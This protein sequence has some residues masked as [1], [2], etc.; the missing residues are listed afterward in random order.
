[1]GRR[2]RCRRLCP[3]CS[4]W[5]LNWGSFRGTVRGLLA[6]L[7]NESQHRA[8]FDRL[9]FGDE[10][11]EQYSARRSSHFGIDLIGNDLQQRIVLCNGIA[12]G[13]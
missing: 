5:G 12:F 10:D 13:P 8:H 11:L 4:G 2:R 1:L 9:T 7:S 3:C 6:R